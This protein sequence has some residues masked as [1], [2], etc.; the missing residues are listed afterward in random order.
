MSMNAP[1]TATRLRERARA[2]VTAMHG[3]RRTAL[4]WLLVLAFM[5]VSFPLGEML[6]ALVRIYNWPLVPA[7]GS[8]AERVAA[9]VLGLIVAVVGT[10]WSYF[11]ATLLEGLMHKRAEVLLLVRPAGAATVTLRPMGRWTKATSLAGWPRGTGLGREIAEHARAH[12]WRAGHPLAA[13][14]V[15]PMARR[16]EAAGMIVTRRWLG[17][18]WCRVED[19]HGPASIGNVNEQSA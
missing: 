9:V 12:A 7:A 2:G 15:A 3:F 6:I 14:A 5:G 8:I 18:L 1:I 17:G 11:T 4:F 19:H 10:S 16:Y 13:Y